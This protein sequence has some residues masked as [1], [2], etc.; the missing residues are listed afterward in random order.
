MAASLLKNPYAALMGCA[1][2]GYAISV[3]WPGIVSLA[4]EKFPNGG[5][6][7]YGAIAMAGDIGCSAAPYITGIVA[8]MEVWG[9]NGLKA[10]MFVSIVYPIVYAAAFTAFTVCSRNGKRS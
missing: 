10:G 2:C 9:N 1:L 6:A 8:S 4:A 5:G 7:M 3:M